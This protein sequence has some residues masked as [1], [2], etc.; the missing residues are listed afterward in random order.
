MRFRK[1]LPRVMGHSVYLMK[2]VLQCAMMNQYLNGEAIFSMKK[3]NWNTRSPQKPTVKR[4][5]PSPKPFFEEKEE[6]RDK[7]SNIV[8]GFSE[9]WTQLFT[10]PVHL[11]SAL[12]KLSPRLKSILAQI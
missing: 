8:D 1:L 5:S 6:K 3:R 7:T 11:D 4:R 12:S 9:L 2:L 10:T